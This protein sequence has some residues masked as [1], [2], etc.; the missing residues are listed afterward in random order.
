MFEGIVDLPFG[1]QI[2]SFSASVTA[3]R[4]LAVCRSK[5]YC[6]LNST[7]PTCH[8]LLALARIM[9]VSGES[10]ARALTWAMNT[11]ASRIAQAIG[12]LG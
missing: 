10:G 9:E 1:E 7:Q 8:G 12:P 6:P 4:L 3:L 11:L 2:A 5:M